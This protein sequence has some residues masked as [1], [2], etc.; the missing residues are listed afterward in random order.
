[1]TTIT[2]DT[3]V[4][5][6]FNYS[7]IVKVLKKVNT[8]NE[9]IMNVITSGYDDLNGYSLMDCIIYNIIKNDKSELLQ[10]LIDNYPE[11]EVFHGCALDDP[12]EVAR[13]NRA[14]NCKR[15]LKSFNSLSNTDVKMQVA[16]QR[17]NECNGKILDIS[18]LNLTELPDNLPENLQV[19]Y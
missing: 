16:L 17:I 8:T 14:E 13:I 3:F 9:N 10:F 1:M 5:Y 15:I 12:H 11:C 7:N 4:E 19:L 2:I 6:I 18:N